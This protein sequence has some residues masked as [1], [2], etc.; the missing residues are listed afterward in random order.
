M[1]Q[2]TA[3]PVILV[4]CL[5]AL[6]C[7]ERAPQVAEFPP[8]ARA[9]S[10]TFRKGD[11]A[12][13]RD[14][15]QTL[16]KDARQRQDAEAERGALMGLARAQA[17]LGEK[18]AAERSYE[19]LWR[20]RTAAVGAGD[21]S[22]YWDALGSG[23]AYSALGNAARARES[24]QRAVRALDDAPEKQKWF[25]DAQL[26][27]RWMMLRAGDASQEAAVRAGVRESRGKYSFVVLGYLKVEKGNMKVCGWNRQ[28]ADIEAFARDLGFD[29]NPFWQFQAPPE[30]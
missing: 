27:P 20:T 26:F 3:H 9:A 14:Q 13:A 24:F 8:D 6:G 29:Q 10:K 18:A 12:A 22:L 17:C 28:I 25:A 4:V 11:L 1:R 15:Y 2:R 19:E 5:A 7:G 16:L 21:L 23:L 30:G